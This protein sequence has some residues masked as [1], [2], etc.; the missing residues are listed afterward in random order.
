MAR[1]TH[2]EKITKKRELLVARTAAAL[3]VTLEEAA[4]LLDITKKQSVRINTLRTNI[5]EC[6]QE[7]NRLGWQGDRLPWIEEGL[8]VD[9]GLSQ[10]RD[11]ELF[12]Q[13]SIYIQNAASW[14]P[15]IVLDPQKGERVLDLCAAPG[16]KT[17]HLA[18]IANNEAV[19]TAN[20]NSRP[21]LMK[22]REIC[23]RM[24][25][26][27][28]RFSLF[29]ARYIA[30]KLEGESYDKILIDAPCS[31]EGMMRLGEDKDFINWSLPQIK[32][33][34]QLQKRLVSQAWQLLEPGGT[35]VYS[36]CTMAPE[37]N[38]AIVDYA[39]R[40]LE[41][42]SLADIESEL[43]NRA[44]AVRNWS[45]RDFRDQVASCLRLKPSEQIEAFFVAKLV[46]QA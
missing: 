24:N 15:V 14:L 16:G 26:K 5:N 2:Q 40:K 18:A 42:A 28:N 11:S 43:P 7:M 12:E 38:E 29:D 3:D 31:G 37:E 45:G 21:R 6:L 27:V 35:L 44:P 32:R 30:K 34:Q 41:G 25:A 23:R 19:I 9:N 46:K 4:Q 33:L 13:G 36:T 10:L 17:T 20:D 1:T 22:M 39:L 8:T